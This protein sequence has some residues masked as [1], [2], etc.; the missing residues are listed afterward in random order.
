MRHKK[1][2][3]RKIHAD[4]IYN[5]Q[6]I[7]KLINYI[8]RDGKKST[9]EAQVYNA[10]DILKAKGEDPIK[11]FEKAVQNVGPVVEVRARRVGGA[12]YQVPTEVKHERR[13][14]LALRWIIESSRKRPNKEYHTFAYKLAAELTDAS[15]NLGEAIRKRDLAL[16]QAEANKAFA[17]FRW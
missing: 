13:M 17:H 9:A 3:K 5:N 4:T 16:K 10:L 11:L 14:S 1:V 8:M 15:Q 2:N 6:L 7:T 12:N